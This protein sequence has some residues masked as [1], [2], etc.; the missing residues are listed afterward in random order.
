MATNQ[1]LHERRTLLPLAGI[2]LSLG[3]LLLVP[4]VVG[5]QSQELR[6]AMIEKRVPLT[7]ATEAFRIAA[8][9]EMAAARVSLATGDTAAV[10]WAIRAASEREATLRELGARVATLDTGLD[11]EFRTLASTVERLPQPG[12]YGLATADSAAIWAAWEAVTS[13]S[14]DF[15]AAIDV[16]I[17]AD[18]EQISALERTGFLMTAALALLAF[19]SALVSYRMEKQVRA[20]AHESERARHEQQIL[21]AGAEEAERRATFLAAASELF[22]ASLDLD[23]TLNSL[24]A[25]VVPGIADSCVIY[26]IDASGSIQRLQPVHVDVERQRILSEQLDRY[27]PRIETLIPPVRLALTDGTPSLVHSVSA[28]ELKAV[29]GDSTHRS[30]IESIGL[31]SLIVVP[32]R[33]RGKIVGAISY[34]AA[35]SRR[36]YGP[37]D[38]ALAEDLSNRAGLALD[39][40]R[41]YQESQAA[42]GARN[43]V[44]GIV[45][46]DLRNPLNAVRFGAQALLRHWPPHGDGE[47]EKNQLG[48]ITKA[49]DR[50]HRLIRDLLD[51]AQIDAGKLAVD[52]EPVPATVLL[53]DAVELAGPAAADRGIRLLTESPAEAPLL[54]VDGERILQVF[55]NLIGNAIRYS[56]AGSQVSVGGTRCGEELVFSVRDQGRGIDAEAIPHIFNRF[57]RERAGSRDGGAGLGLAIAR[58]IVESH[59]GRIWVESAVGGG[60]VFYFALPVADTVEVPAAR[61]DRR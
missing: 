54:M 48:A 55:S 23:T 25:L 5:R 40:A 44:L 42:V 39:N 1:V 41:L 22:A 29:P 60:S 52:P 9:D 33:A 43:E 13:A 8:V 30:V 3:A 2:I 37:D 20:F 27:P 31:Q 21:R 61:N 35:E 28:E 16:E 36:E 17:A 47:V 14:D 49:A 12:S 56:P 51:V 45:S 34:G 7:L 58:G 19:F 24:S 32:L 6:D 18:D 4:I 15:R 59:G 26:L 11:N 46:H 50:M 57:W 38:L 53:Q 10:E